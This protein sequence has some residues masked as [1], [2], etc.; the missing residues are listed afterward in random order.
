[1]SKSVARELDIRYWL[2]LLGF[3]VLVVATAAWMGLDY[4]ARARH[5]QE[6]SL[7]EWRNNVAHVQRILDAER[8]QARAYDDVVGLLNEAPG[9]HHLAVINSSGQILQANRP[10]LRGR[11]ATAAFQ[12]IDAARLDPA[13]WSPHSGTMALESDAHIRGYFPL[14]VGAPTD[15]SPAPPTGLLYLDVDTSYARERILRSLYIQTVYFALFSLVSLLGLL[16]FIRRFVSI[17]ASSASAIFFIRSA[18]R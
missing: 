18:M 13:R 15:G 5:S 8:E 17:S 4:S 11:P 9:L 16:M 12:N 6:T 2:P 10:E 3:I 14:A 7:A 1:M